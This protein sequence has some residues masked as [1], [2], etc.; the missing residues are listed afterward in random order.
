MQHQHQPIGE[1][2]LHACQEHQQ[3]HHLDGGDHDDDA[4]ADTADGI[5]LLED[6]RGVT[7]IEELVQRPHCHHEE[8]PE[9]QQQQGNADSIGVLRHVNSLQRKWAWRKA[10]GACRAHTGRA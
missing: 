10:A 4:F 9:A 2:L 7:G 3:Q 8:D 5:E 1:G 6:G